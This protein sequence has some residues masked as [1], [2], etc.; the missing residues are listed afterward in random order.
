MTKYFNNKISFLSSPKPLKAFS[1]NLFNGRHLAVLEYCMRKKH[2][3]HSYN[4]IT[5]IMIFPLKSCSTFT[6]KQFIV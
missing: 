5:P 4:I 2:R 1:I 6:N 3:V